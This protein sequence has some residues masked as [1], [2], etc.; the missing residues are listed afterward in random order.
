[1]AGLESYQSGQVQAVSDEEFAHLLGRAIP[2]ESWHIGQELRLN[3]PLSKMQYAKSSLARMVYKILYRLLKKAEKKG[4]PDLNLLFLYNMPFRALGKMT[5]DRIDQ[6]MVAAIL[7]IVN[8]HLLKGV[9][10]L[11]RAF[12]AKQSYQ[13]QLS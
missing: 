5:G 2:V 7:V 6:Q 1:M 11:W 9:G 10:Q 4:K 8:G 13:K 12:R 3:D